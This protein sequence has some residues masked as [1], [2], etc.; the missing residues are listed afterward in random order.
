[1]ALI[2]EKP[3]ESNFFIMIIHYEL[4]KIHALTRLL[5]IIGCPKLIEF[6]ILLRIL[7]LPQAQLHFQQLAHPHQHFLQLSHLP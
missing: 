1:M 7:K 3:A 2:H 6:I 5:Q 4:M